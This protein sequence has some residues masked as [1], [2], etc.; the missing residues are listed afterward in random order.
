M[1]SQLSITV[2]VDYQ[3]DDGADG[4]VQPTEAF[5]QAVSGTRKI[6]NVQTVGIAEEVLL[7]GDVPAGGVLWAICRG[8]VGTWVDIVLDSGS[9]RGIRFSGGKS[10]G[11]LPGITPGTVPFVRASEDFVDLEIFA[12]E[13]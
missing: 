13:V 2:K 4:R 11:L 5:A 7:L 10:P 8:D 12:F 9:G 1:S 3:L 6:G